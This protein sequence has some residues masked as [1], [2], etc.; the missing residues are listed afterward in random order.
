MF[1]LFGLGWQAIKSLLLAQVPKLQLK[2]RK[3]LIMLIVYN[4]GKKIL[5][6]QTLVLYYKWRQTWAKGQKW[7][8]IEIDKYMKRII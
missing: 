8:L 3:R 1:G 4:F 5:G 7:S 6:E 2:A